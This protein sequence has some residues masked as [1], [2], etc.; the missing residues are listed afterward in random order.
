MNSKLGPKYIPNDPHELSP[1]GSLLA[2]I[3]ERQNLI[4]GNGSQ[5]CRGTITRKRTTS[6]RT[7]TSA[8]DV[9]MFSNDLNNHLVS[10][11]IDEDRKHVLSRIH[12][13]K[14]GTKIKESD[15]NSII[16]ELDCRIIKD[17][18]EKKVELFDLKDKDSQAKF[19]AYTTG[20]NML[21]SIFNNES[22]DIDDLTNRLVKKINGSIAINFKKRRVSKK[23]SL[24]VTYYTTE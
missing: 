7:E 2:A 18:D 16:T 21:S 10:V 3:I 17:K 23:K 4:V 9:V 5:K 6:D 13:T 22:D 15:H 24:R 11:H 20:T 8:I 12:K 1:N 19:K 14:R